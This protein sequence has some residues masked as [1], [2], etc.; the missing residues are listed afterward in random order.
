MTQEDIAR[1]RK[2]AGVSP[3]PPHPDNEAIFAAR[4]KAMG[5][6]DPSTLGT[7]TPSNIEPTYPPAPQANNPSALDTMGNKAYDMV[8]KPFVDR[9]GSQFARG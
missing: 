4:R 2:E 9:F 3:N 7:T 5:I 1:I 6:P 8:A